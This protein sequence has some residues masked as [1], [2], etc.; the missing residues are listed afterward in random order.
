MHVH[1]QVGGVVVEGPALRSCVD[2]TEQ[3][4]ACLLIA[5]TDL[6]TADAG[7]TVEILWRCRALVLWSSIDWIIVGRLHGLILRV[8]VRT[9]VRCEQLT[10]VRN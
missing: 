1:D 8:L 7:A 3:Q 2:Y 9:A 10:V 5:C 6:V 4:S